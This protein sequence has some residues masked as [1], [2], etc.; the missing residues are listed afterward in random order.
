MGSHYHQLALK[1]PIYWGG[2]DFLK[3]YTH[4]YT[5]THTRTQTFTLYIHFADS[6]V[7]MNKGFAG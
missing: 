2:G 1:I 3:S 7:Y 5:Y 6:A 4:T